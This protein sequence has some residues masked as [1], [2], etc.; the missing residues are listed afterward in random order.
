MSDNIYTPPGDEK[1]FILRLK[2]GEQE[3]YRLLVR[4][5]RSKLL[6][7]AL[8]I[9]LDREESLDIV[10]DVF[11]K[12]YGRIH[13]FEGKSSLYT[14]L[15]RITVNESL[16]W[17]RKWKRRFRWHHESLEGEEEG[18]SIELK[19]DEIDPE[20]LFQKKELE[21]IVHQG[22]NRLPEEARAILILKELE[23][24]SYKEIARYLKIKEGTVSSRIYSAREKLKGYL[25][26]VLEKEA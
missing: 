3:A 13:L 21:K 17:R 25:S 14:W 23:G 4:Q 1:E 6:H 8:G 19:A 7:I 11:L 24:L 26:T 16:N 9:T 18:H 12:V 5:Y 10:Q 22:L 2:K 15:R 20:G